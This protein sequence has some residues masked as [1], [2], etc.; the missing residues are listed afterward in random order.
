VGRINVPIRPWFAGTCCAISEGFVLT[1]R[2]VLEAIAT[3]SAAGA[4]TLKWPNETTVDFDAEDGATAAT[5]FKVMSVAF[6]GPDAIN[7]IIDFAHLD[8]AVLGVDPATD[9]ASAFPKPVT[10]ETD[11][12]QPKMRR[13]LYVVGFPGQPR[14]WMFEGKPPGGYETAQVISTVFNSRFRVKRLAPGSVKAGPGDIATDSKKWV[15]A[16]DASTLMGN[17]GSCIADLT[18]D[19]LR[20]IGLHFGGVNRDQNWA[21]AAARLREFLSPFSAALV[22]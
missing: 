9:P 19:G 6:A 16:H 1:N 15:C 11:V 5:K 14:T 18:G 20:V 2:H 13:D 10:F 7:E 4:W 21:H 22:A 3:Q 8:V 12:L 17:S